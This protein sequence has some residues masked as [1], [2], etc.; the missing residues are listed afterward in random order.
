MTESLAYV[1][2]LIDGEGCVH[3]CVSTKEIG[4][5]YRGRVTIGM[6]EP[7]LP[8]LKWLHQEWGGSLANSRQATDKWS[9]AWVWTL[10]GDQARELLRQ[11]SPYL[12]LK[13]PQARLVLEV[14]RIRADLPRRPN[15]SGQWNSRARAECEAIKAKL[16]R[17]NAKGERAQNAEDSS[18]PRQ[19]LATWNPR[20]MLWETDQAD[21]FSA[22]QEPY[23]ETFATSGMTRSGRLLPL[24]ASAPPTDE[25]EYSSLL[26]TPGADL[27]EQHAPRD[28]VQR[29][30]NGQQVSLEDAACYLPTP[31]AMD[32]VAPKNASNRQAQRDRGYGMDLREAVMD[33]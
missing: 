11:V 20:R 30:A 24:P 7:A 9:A 21:L 3:L 27:G 4:A 31:N 16:H 19:P 10:T 17:L 2:G 26:P 8:V 12:K 32:W 28:P 25:N 5:T 22:Q 13:A 29:R 18:L 15:G 23:S 6:T 14:E 33:L 1:A